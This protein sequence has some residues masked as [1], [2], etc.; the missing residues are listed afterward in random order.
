MK[1]FAQSDSNTVPV[2]SVQRVKVT[3]FH[4]LKWCF[5]L[6]WCS[7]ASEREAQPG[8]KMLECVARAKL[9][10]TLAGCMIS[11]YECLVIH[12]RQWET[13]FGDQA[14]CIVWLAFEAVTHYPEYGV[15]QSALMFLVAAKSFEK[16]G[17]GP[18]V[19]R[20]CSI[21]ARLAASAC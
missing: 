19:L 5:F 7:S 4:P 1:S 15:L 3:E 18:P 12:L 14:G 9:G 13:P 17:L 16:A 8:N 2:W 6:W 10:Q 21:S 11:G 20:V